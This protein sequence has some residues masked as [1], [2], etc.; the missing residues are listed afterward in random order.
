MNAR[1]NRTTN[2]NLTH[3]NKHVLK[4]ALERVSLLDYVIAY[5][6]RH[7]LQM[8]GNRFPAV[9]R[10]GRGNNCEVCKSKNGHEY[11]KDHVNNEV[12]GVWSWLTK[13]ESLTKK[14]AAEKIK[15]DA[16]MA[17]TPHTKSRIQYGYPTA[18]FQT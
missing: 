7:G 10:D 17:N 18:K 8:R 14:Q 11:V 15:T 3:S 5:L 12:F 13:I 9:W 1:Q 6:E 2:H 4:T 16:G